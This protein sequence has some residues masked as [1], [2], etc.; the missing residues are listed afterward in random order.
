MTFPSNIAPELLRGRL[1][2]ITGAGQG[3]GRAIA[4]GLAQAGARV[5]VT[6]MN[7]SAVDETAALVKQ[8]GAEAWAFPLDVTSEEACAELAIRMGEKI[9]QIDLL[10]NNAGIIILEGM[11]SPKESANW[12]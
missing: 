12:R 6:D 3:N 2:L 11:S 4:L 5:V 1:A 10:V 7:A 9:G 8:S